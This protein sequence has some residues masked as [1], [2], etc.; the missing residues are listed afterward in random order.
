MFSTVSSLGNFNNNQYLY[1]KHG[2]WNVIGGTNG[3]TTI[4]T[5]GVR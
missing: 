4:G 2:Y 1:N 5:G 3:S